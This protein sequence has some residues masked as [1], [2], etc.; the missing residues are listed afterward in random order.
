MNENEQ[1]DGEEMFIIEDSQGLFILVGHL[2][3]NQS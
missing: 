1:D 2:K 3:T